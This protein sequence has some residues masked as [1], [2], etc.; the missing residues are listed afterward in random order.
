M[1][2]SPHIFQGK[3]PAKERGSAGDFH[4]WPRDFPADA[5][6]RA[7]CKLL[8]ASNSALQRRAQHWSRQ[9]SRQSWWG[10]GKKSILRIQIHRKNYSCRYKS[11]EINRKNNYRPNLRGPNAPI[12]ANIH[13]LCAAIH[14]INASNQYTSKINMA[15][16]R[17]WLNKHVSL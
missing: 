7:G 13:L 2:D 1:L 11:I 3:E 12:C 8:G 4:L 14:L 15:S 16:P 9:T 10:H 17:W 6:R 5:A